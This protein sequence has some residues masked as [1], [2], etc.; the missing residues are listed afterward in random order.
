M[1]F[2]YLIFLSC[3][4]ILAIVGIIGIYFNSKSWRKYIFI[5]SLV[6]FMVAYSYQPHGSSDLTRYLEYISECK[7]LTFFQVNQ[8]F[9]DSLYV[10]N[11]FFWLVALINN[12]HLIPAITTTIVYGVTWYITCDSAEM[13]GNTTSLPIVLLLQTMCLQFV[14]IINN[15]R[16]V[17]AFSLVI[18]AAY[19]ELV[20]KRK[21]IFIYILY[22]I[23]IF[24]H[25]SALVLVI[26]R[27]MLIL[28]RIVTLLLVGVMI[29]FPV[30]LNFVYS[31]GIAKFLG[32]FMNEN[33]D[34]LW[35]YLNDP[36]TSVYSSYVS[37]SRAFMFQRYSMMGLAVIML[38]AYIYVRK[39]KV[40]KKLY[41]FESFNALINVMTLACWPIVTPMYWRFSTAAIASS[42]TILSRIWANKG[43]GAMIIKILLFVVAFFLVIIHYLINRYYVSL[44]EWISDILINDFYVVIVKF[45]AGILGFRI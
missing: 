12:P 27:I 26:F 1:L 39:N 23:P 16:N 30:L 6:I 37:S 9:G 42:G 11:F 5:L 3:T 38:V 32:S 36:L 28:P 13:K 41:L 19:L 20:K 2:I 31:S 18:L 40:G 8:L 14:T 45:V 21:S 44:G 34:K 17:S 29:F 7:G 24:I 25:P 10:K 4:P 33:L 15:V 35:D 43:T 22:V